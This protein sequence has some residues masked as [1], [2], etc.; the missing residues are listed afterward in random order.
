[1]AGR[2]SYSVNLALQADPRQLRRDLDKARR[3]WSNF[4]RDV[5]RTITRM[6]KAGAVA[7]GALAASFV[8]ATKQAANLADE[9]GKSA[10]A[11]GIAAGDYQ[12]LVHAIERMG[13][14]VAV[15]EKAMFRLQQAIAGTASTT[16]AKV[17]EEMGLSVEK[18]GSSA[19]LDAF[20]D[21]LGALGQIENAT[22]RNAK[23]IDLFGARNAKSI[24]LLVDNLQTYRNEVELAGR[25]GLFSQQSIQNAESLNDA[26]ADLTRSVQVGFGNAV[27]EVL[28]I[29]RSTESW[30]KTVET[31]RMG[32]EK[33]TKG[34]LNFT[35][36]MYEHRQ[37][38]ATVA[39]IWAGYIA[40]LIAGRV[41]AG[42]KAL[43]LGFKALAAATVIFGRALKRTPLGLLVTG[44]A[45]VGTA[46]GGAAAGAAGGS[47]DGLLEGLGLGGLTESL[48]NFSRQV[49]MVGADVI[50]L[51]GTFED[52]S[53]DVVK[54]TDAGAELGA[55]VVTAT[56]HTAV[57]D[58]AIGE[59]LVR[60][61]KAAMAV[62]VYNE[63]IGP[64][65]P[66]WVTNLRQAVTRASDTFR[67]TLGEAF[68]S[69][70]FGDV[71]EAT[72]TTFKRS[73]A[74]SLSAAITE[75][76]F[77]PVANALTNA[78]VN[79][80]G[81]VFGNIGGSLGNIVGGLFGGGGGINGIAS[82]VGSALG[83]GKIG[84]AIAGGGA[85]AGGAGG[86]IA[87]GIGGSLSGLTGKRGIRCARTRCGGA[88][89]IAVQTQLLRQAARTDQPEPQ[90]DRPEPAFHRSTTA[91]CG[92]HR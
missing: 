51:G 65:F 15:T 33:A 59:N 21:V 8:A 91:A 16:Y 57:Y 78:L 12:R 23:A 7:A 82:S 52:T 46:L 80:V 25:V 3:T 87:G 36:A 34:F 38:I 53:R 42:I 2:G 29:D 72:A 17:L 49:G 31:V 76:L 85:A 58:K 63:Q 70:N 20:N 26:I 56:R 37:I 54:L 28:N 9:V 92:G 71:A 61:R 30:G 32:V 81:G 68:L 11:A 19:P 73:L 41:F 27:L 79:V 5:N 75:R 86:G 84:G 10:R 18:L 62:Q 55:V 69:G 39:K 60:L 45:A 6:S 66:R 47:Y 88:C 40:A 89:S 43:I 22:Q 67:H 44:V 4:G 48:G 35:K 74:H 90:P 1:M 64:E 14:N 50:D 83:L 24:L 13:G 77:D